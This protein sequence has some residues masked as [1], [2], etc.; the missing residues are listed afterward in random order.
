MLISRLGRGS[1]ELGPIQD[2]VNFIRKHVFQH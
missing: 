1:N 2:V